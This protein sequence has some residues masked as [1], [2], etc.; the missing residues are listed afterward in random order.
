VIRPVLFTND[1]A[2]LKKTAGRWKR[3]NNSAVLSRGNGA[4]DG[5]SRRLLKAMAKKISWL[6]AAEIAGVSD[7][8]MRRLRQRYQE[9]GYTGLFDQ[10]RGRRGLARQ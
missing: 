4:D 3:G 6:A 2:A 10:R 5:T 1:L 8:T 9:I 7:R